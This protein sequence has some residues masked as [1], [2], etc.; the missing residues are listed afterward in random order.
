MAKVLPLKLRV[1]EYLTQVDHPVTSQNVYDALKDEY[2]G[3]RQMKYSRI[4]EYMQ[5]LLGVN[6]VKESGL[7][8]DK[9]GVLQVYYK[10]SD[11]GKSRIKYIPK[12]N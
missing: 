8:Y 9:K 6:M 3:E 2:K 5:A 10:V 4:D 7:E 1:F 12:V 11:F